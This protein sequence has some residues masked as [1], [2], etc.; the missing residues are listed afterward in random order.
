MRGYYPTTL[1]LAEWKTLVGEMKR[2]TQDFAAQSEL[3]LTSALVERH[4]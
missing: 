1:H 3:S 2:L 4:R